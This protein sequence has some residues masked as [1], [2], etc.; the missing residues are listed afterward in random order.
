[1][2]TFTRFDFGLNASV[3]LTAQ[4]ASTWSPWLPRDP[5]L[6]VPVHLDVLM[7]RTESSTAVWAET[8]LSG[9]DLQAPP[10]FTPRSAPRGKGAYLLWAPPDALARGRKPH[11]NEEGPIEFPPLPER[12]LVLRMSP[13]RL[14]TNRRTLRGW[15]LKA[16]EPGTPPI[17]LDQYVDAI[18]PLDG[19]STGPAVTAVGPGQLDWIGYFD[20]VENRFGFHDSLT[21]VS[22]GPIAY[23]VCGWYRD[24]DRDP[25][26]D[27]DIRT[28]AQFE[29]LLSDF[30][31]HLPDHLFKQAQSRAIKQSEALDTMGLA[32]IKGVKTAYRSSTMAGQVTDTVT[33]A[34]AKSLGRVKVAQA[35]WWP[36]LSL[37]HGA[38]VGIGW[39]NA[40]LDE[41]GAAVLGTGVG[42]AEVGGPPRPQDV[43]VGFGATLTDALAAMIARRDN[44][45]LERA[46]V[47]QA[48]QLGAMNE[49]DDPDGRAK[50][51]ALLHSTTFTSLLGGSITERVWQPPLGEP[52]AE[53]VPKVAGPGVFERYYRRD[54]K[55]TRGAGGKALLGKE[56]KR[57]ASASSK[58]RGGTQPTDERQ[59]FSVKSPSSSRSAPFKGASSI[60]KA[61]AAAPPSQFKATA[62]AGKELMAQTEVAQG[63][64][65]RVSQI[66]RT[67][68]QVTP[69]RPGRWVDRER[70]LPRFYRPLDPQLVIEGIKRAYQYGGDGRFS[71]DGWLGCRLSGTPVKDYR[72]KSFNRTVNAEDF[73]DRSISNGS[74]PPECEDLLNELALL[75]PGSSLPI[76]RL[77]TAKT[78]AS[79]T[80]QRAIADTVQVQQT[81]WW[82]TRDPR[83]DPSAVLSLAP[84]AGTLPS[85]VAINVPARPWNPLHLEWRVEYIASPRQIE[86]WTLGE[87]DYNED[88]PDLPPPSSVTPLPF[89]GRSPLS[90]G[91]GRTIAG[92]I[93][94]T[95]ADANAE[96]ADA[97]GTVL[98]HA[99]QAAESSGAMK[100][101]QQL[102]GM[103]AGVGTADSIDAQDRATLGDIAAALEQSDLLS[104]SLDGL[105]TKLRAGFIGDGAA[106]PGD[107]SVPP[108]FVALRSG[109]LRIVRLRVVDAFGQ[110]LDLAGSSEASNPDT[111]TKAVGRSESL[112]VTS[113]PEWLA[114]P[115]RLTS[116]ARLWL[117]F[118]DSKGGPDEA[119][120]KTDVDEEI[121]PVCG[122]LMPN[123]LDDALLF[124]ADDGRDLGV[125]RRNESN[126]IAW[127]DAPGAPSTVGAS[128]AQAISNPFAA[129]IAQGLT[130]WGAS[131]AG[132]LDGSQD[133]DT[134]LRALM[135]VIDTTRWTVDPFGHQ[136]E[137][138]LALL[139][140]QPV[141]VVRAVLRLEV[142]EPVDLTKVEGFAMPVRLGALTQWQDGLLG[143]FVDD[144]Y[145][146]LHCSQASVAELA[147]AFG[148]SQGFLQAVEDVPA[149]ADSF[150][151]NGAIVPITHPYVDRSGVITMRP[152]RDVKLTLLV[153]PHTL[154]HATCGL[155]PRKE[156]GLR[157]EWTQDALAKL[158]PTFRFGPVLVDPKKVRMPVAVDLHGTWSWDHRTDVTTWENLPVAHATHDALFPQD[159]PVGSEGWL[160]LRP[161][162]P[163]AEAQEG[164]GP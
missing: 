3:G 17:P 70:P 7:V 121:T 94:R 85:P 54:G 86:D 19:A 47:L 82:A 150:G 64:L 146:T 128:P 62:Y 84:F 28:Q 37:Y 107:G 160:R 115:P 90:A 117:R 92:A 41:R 21:D 157:R 35:A 145:R 139:V 102:S 25:L 43:K 39:P 112:E 13:S 163:E 58:A 159:A 89:E 44:N 1:M 11:D 132:L 46:R 79:A 127:E 30:R 91:V 61:A 105:H 119:R 87:I 23:L 109:F 69:Y 80:T 149:Y 122:Y 156:V 120:D 8:G 55:G 53:A 29:A 141:V 140:G 103:V 111:V 118:M 40:A 59:F 88:V 34:E 136:G 67:G 14:I 106:A 93:R 98:V 27:P 104:G 71:R 18:E 42:G 22:T 60:A 56:G 134:A 45:H 164:Q 147:R 100:F 113:R 51:D 9:A 33:K 16:D 162:D 73:L 10:P 142:D 148:Q 68:P 77:A 52:P 12:W 6:L 152:N 124:Y 96:R 38:V 155:L 4:M 75:D 116:P 5:R 31:W 97:G 74:M 110:V 26:S 36:R 99:V 66:L 151:D 133:S 76:A 108:N 153:E 24:P 143:Y 144:D 114:L 135:R 2:S 129:G 20:N 95:L 131:D 158:S 123:H 65:G 130:D 81:A 78:R 154:V 48:F 138:H 57:T 50:L 126:R 63:N 83:T 72:L 161:F 49:L 32:I 125:V 15:V 101:S 137:E